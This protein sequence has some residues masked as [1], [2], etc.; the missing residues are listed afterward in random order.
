MPAKRGA[1][2]ALGLDVRHGTRVQ[3]QP[4]G[5]T[6]RKTLLRLEPDAQRELAVAQRFRDR[7]IPFEEI[8]GPAAVQMLACQRDA[9]DQ[10]RETKLALL[11][12]IARLHEHP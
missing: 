6:R 3:P 9:A 8:T 1:R 5:G 12:Q 4:K 11:T 10:N 2:P 7:I